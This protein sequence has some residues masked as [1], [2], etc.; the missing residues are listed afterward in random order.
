MFI[1]DSK[2]NIHGILPTYI[3]SGYSLSKVTY[4]TGK[5]S[6][7]ISLH[8]QGSKPTNNFTIEE[9]ATTW[10]SKAL[11]GAVVQPYVGNDFKTYQV[12]GRSVFYYNNTVVWI[13]AGIYYTLNNH[14]DLTPKQINQIVNTT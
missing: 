8:Y 11:V 10:D 3:P 5:A 12:S 13:D 2:T 1:A 6:G 7:T 9:Q 14:A 4:T